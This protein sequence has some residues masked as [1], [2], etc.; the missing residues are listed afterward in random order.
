[1]LVGQG[2]LNTAK[3]G[4]AV[5][6]QRVWGKHAALLVRDRL[7]NARSGGAFGMTAQWGSRIAGQE[8]DSK[9]GMRGGQR[10]R[11][12]E[13]VKELITASDFGYFIEDAVA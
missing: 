5:S 7:A 13:S 4:Q 11:A 12:G 6:L 10:V 2:W 9:I 8:A 3:P 1:M